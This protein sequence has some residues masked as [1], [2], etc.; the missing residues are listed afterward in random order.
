[1]NWVIAMIFTRSK[2]LIAKNGIIKMITN[3]T[4]TKTKNHFK[5]KSA[6]QQV[7]R[8]A[9]HFSLDKFSMKMTIMNTMILSKILRRIK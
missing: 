2:I 9:I 4:A 7:Q 8:F 6:G 5:M 1:M 3:S